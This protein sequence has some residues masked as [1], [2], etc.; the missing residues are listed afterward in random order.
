MENLAK[1]LLA[2]SSLLNTSECAKSK[3]SQIFKCLVY[4]IADKQV[5][6]VRRSCVRGVEES[7]VETGKTYDVRYQNKKVY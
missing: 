7:A 2:E 1:D 5:S 6:I 3:R 4:W